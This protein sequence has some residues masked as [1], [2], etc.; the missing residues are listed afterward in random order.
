MYRPPPGT[1]VWFFENDKVEKGNWKARM[2]FVR[3]CLWLR[4]Y[5]K[6]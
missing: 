6:R 3:Y 5:G 2:R 4:D 1:L